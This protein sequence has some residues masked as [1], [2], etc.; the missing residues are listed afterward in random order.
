MDLTLKIIKTKANLWSIYQ[1]IKFGRE[2]IE[3]DKPTAL[4][5]INGAKQSE[6]ELLEA[7][8]SFT[9]LSDH[10]ITLSRE[11]SELAR[12][13]ILLLEQLRILKDELKYKDCAL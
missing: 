11:N 3:K 12:R 9:D 2:K 8:D 4:D 13:N 6:E 7:Y 10:I 1:R 5:Y